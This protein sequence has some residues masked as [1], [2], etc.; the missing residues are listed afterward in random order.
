MHRLDEAGVA[1]GDDAEAWRAL[2]LACIGPDEARPD[3]GAELLQRL[4]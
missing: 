1:S 3:G 4:P 2:A